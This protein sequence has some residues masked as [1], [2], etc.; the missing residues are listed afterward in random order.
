M[1]DRVN[2]MADKQY[3]PAYNI[4]RAYFMVMAD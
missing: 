2:N 1:K 3:K 4:R